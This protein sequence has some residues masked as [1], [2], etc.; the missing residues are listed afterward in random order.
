AA[1][2]PERDLERAGEDV[3]LLLELALRLDERVR[4][5]ALDLR[6]AP[7]G[8]GARDPRVERLA[9]RE[10]GVLRGGV[11]LPRLLDRGVDAR[12]RLGRERDLD[13]LAVGLVREGLR[14]RRRLL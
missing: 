12:A 13:E 7:R 10:V 9:E 6:R 2:D 3:V 11:E 8:R 14:E 1:S 5:P 4:A